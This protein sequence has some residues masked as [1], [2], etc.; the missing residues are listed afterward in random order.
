MNDNKKNTAL[1]LKPTSNSLKNYINIMTDLNEIYARIADFMGTTINEK[2]NLKIKKIESGSLFQIISGDPEVL[3]ATISF[4]GIISKLFYNEYNK[5]NEIMK[6]KKIAEAIKN[7]FEIFE[8]AKKQGIEVPDSSKEDLQH[9][10]EVLTK[11][12]RNLLTNI[13][14]IQIND[15]EMVE[16]NNHFKNKYIE[17]TTKRIEKNQENNNA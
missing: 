4:L 5:R 13:S 16:V 10:L 12:S 1:L 3:A 7:D 11:D 8:L 15:N 17:H 9:S 2:N 14:G 6:H